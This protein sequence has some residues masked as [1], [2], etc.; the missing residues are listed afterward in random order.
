[1][2]FKDVKQGYPIYILDKS[3][4][5]IIPGKVVNNTFPHIDTQYD[6]SR[7]VQYGT[8]PKYNQ[9]VVDLT[10]ESKGKTATYTMSESSTITYAGNL[11]LAPTM[12]QLIPEVEAVKNSAE[13]FL[14][15]VDQE[16]VKQKERLDKSLK[17]LGEINPAFKQQQEYDNRL[18][19][20]ENSIGDIK[21]MLSSIFDK[22]NKK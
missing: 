21:D 12:D 9:M 10:I 22:Q 16:K 7:G 4:M 17:L 3:T 2:Q 13:Q 14:N 8:T 18:S 20:L 11:V 15:N 5:E 19:Q 6:P 1:M